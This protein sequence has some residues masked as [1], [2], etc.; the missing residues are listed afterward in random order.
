MHDKGPVHTTPEEFENGGFT[1]KTHQM[2][3]VHTSTPEEFKNA[4]IQSPVILDSAREIT[5]L[6]RCHRFQKDPF[7]KWFPSTLKHKTGD[8]KF[9]RFEESFRKAPFLRCFPFH[10]KTQ[11]RRF[12]IVPVL[13]AFSSIFVFTYIY[14]NFVICYLNLKI[15][16]NYFKR[17][18][19]RKGPFSWRI[20]VEGRPNRRNKAAFSDS[21][22]VV[23]TGPHN[24]HHIAKLKLMVILF[25]RRMVMRWLLWL[26]SRQVT[27]RL[28]VKKCLSWQKW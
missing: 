13:R 25:L 19:L 12:Q 15:N 3:S 26:P 6:S 28:N 24:R 1:L 16:K 8:F 10:A 7:S 17:E 5:R 27:R 9:I 23:R 11:S 2:F 4:T 21:P 18:H 22:G 20:S 14:C